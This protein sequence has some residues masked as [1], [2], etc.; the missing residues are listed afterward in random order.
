MRKHVSIF[1]FL[2]TKCLLMNNLS[3][4]VH[5]F[6]SL[7][8][9]RRF[10][11]AAAQMLSV[12]YLR[13]DV[14]GDDF[15]MSFV[16]KTQIG[17]LFIPDIKDGVNPDFLERFSENLKYMIYFKSVQHFLILP[18]FVLITQLHEHQKKVTS[19]DWK[20]K[21]WINDQDSYDCLRS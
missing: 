16:K 10:L 20:I 15:L 12:M 11:F 18:V 21:G 2:C 6:R 8:S 5:S 17:I 4:F 9:L 19:S 3:L 14:L 13:K 1:S 7:V